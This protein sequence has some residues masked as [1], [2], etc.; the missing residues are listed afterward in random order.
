M[1]ED[2]HISATK[3]IRE[4]REKKGCGAFIFA[5][6]QLDTYVGNISQFS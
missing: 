1:E 5:N 3:S 4:G 6:L 2:K